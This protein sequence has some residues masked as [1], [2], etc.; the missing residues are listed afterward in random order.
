[1]TRAE[2]DRLLE[3]AKHDS[4]N[5]EIAATEIAE[6]LNL[7]GESDLTAQ[8][9]KEAAIKLVWTA[10]SSDWIR[11]MLINAIFGESNR[12]RGNPGKPE[13]REWAIS[14]DAYREHFG[15]APASVRRLAR[16]IGVSRPTVSGWR[17]DP[18]YQKE[19]SEAAR[20]YKDTITV[21]G[22]KPARIK[23]DGILRRRKPT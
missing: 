6:A 4:D 7:V 18:D 14:I 9:M 19:V 22:V 2:L 5:V 17:K 1:M 12:R 16:H 11:V 23:V 15:D 8:E 10:T 13:K 3:A 20:D 21:I